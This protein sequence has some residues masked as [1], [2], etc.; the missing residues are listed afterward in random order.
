MSVCD[1]KTIRAFDNEG[2][3]GDEFDD[4]LL[5]EGIFDRKADDLTAVVAVHTVV[6]LS[7]LPIVRGYGG[8]R[9]S[10]DLDA[11][12]CARHP[13]AWPGR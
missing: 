12:V 4:H 13:A 10:G 3:V 11:D 7:Q 5:C 1:D 9:I 2:S 8:V 6:E